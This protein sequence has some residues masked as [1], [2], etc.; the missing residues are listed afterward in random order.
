M[1]W[2]FY[3]HTQHFNLL[4]KTLRI[5]VLKLLSKEM[6]FLLLLPLTKVLDS[7]RFILRPDQIS[8]SSSSA[9]FTLRGKDMNKSESKPSLEGTKE[10]EE[11]AEENENK[12][13]V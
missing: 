9:Y 8:T 11:P 4:Q 12:L 13:P 7:N 1:I 10:P 5:Q 3:R 2:K 6:V